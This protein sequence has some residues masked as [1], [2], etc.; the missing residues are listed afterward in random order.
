MALLALNSFK[1][2][3][4]LTTASALSNLNIFIIVGPLPAPPA[5]AALVMMLRWLS[6]PITVL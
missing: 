4:E 3:C 2:T 5:A 1:M 6:R